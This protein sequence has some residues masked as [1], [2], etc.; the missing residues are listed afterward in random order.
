MPILVHGVQFVH[1]LRIIVYCHNSVASSHIGTQC[2]VVPRSYTAT[3]LVQGRCCVVVTGPPPHLWHLLGCLESFCN[4]NWLTVNVSKTKVLQLRKTRA[5][6]SPRNSMEYFQYKGE[7]IANVDEFKYL[8]LCFYK[9]A[10]LY[11][12]ANKHLVAVQYE[13]FKLIA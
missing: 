3:A 12:M 13:Q 10:N 8:G 2:N 1:G 9:R 7:H 11:H 6:N 4:T 5:S